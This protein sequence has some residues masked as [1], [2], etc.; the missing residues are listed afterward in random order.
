MRQKLLA[1][2]C[3][4]HTLI[5]AAVIGTACIGSYLLVFVQ[6]KPASSTKAVNGDL[7]GDT[8]RQDVS[9]ANS[10]QAM[11]NSTASDSGSRLPSQVLDLHNWYLTLPIGRGSAGTVSQPALASYNSPYFQTNSTGDTVLFTA[12]VQGSATDN[13]DHTRTELRETAPDGSLPWGWSTGSGTHIMTATE[14]ILHLP[15][16]RGTVGFAQVHGPDS[17]WYLILLAT[18]NGNGTATLLVKDHTGKA[19]GKIIDPNYVLGTKFDLSVSA[20]NGMIT[21]R[22]NGTPK[23]TTINNSSGNY[24]KIGCYNQSSGDYGQV[25]VFSMSVTHS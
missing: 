2:L 15:A 4:K 25:A 17:T 8:S 19:T 20:V 5:L 21:I 22:Y 3:A 18:G 11:K 10:H 16:D 9:S 12:P 24:F 7:A 23:V 1:V 6:N 14:S 13:S